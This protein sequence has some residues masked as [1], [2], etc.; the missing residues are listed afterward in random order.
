MMKSDHRW[1]WA[2]LL[3]AACTQET[4]EGREPAGVGERAPV[5]S[6]VAVPVGERDPVMTEPPGQEAVIDECGDGRITEAESCDDGN[7]TTGDGC[8]ARC[9][10]EWG[11][12]HADVVV[13]A[14]GDHFGAAGNVVDGVNGSVYPLSGEQ[15]RHVTLSWDGFRVLNGPGADLVVFENVWLVDPN[16][17]GACPV[18]VDPVTGEALPTHFMEE[19]V[20]EVSPDCERWVSYPHDYT[21]PDETRYVPY[22]DYWLG[23]A[24]VRVRMLDDRTNPVDPFVPE[25][26]GGDTF[27][28]SVLDDADPVAKAVLD[29]G[30]QCVRLSRAK[31]WINDD[32]DAPFVWNPCSFDG[33]G[34]PD[35]IYAR[36][37]VKE[38][39]TQ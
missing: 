39:M 38:E 14:P 1:I 20:L 19:M 10:T 7:R 5:V 22:Q 11:P 28:L 13:D 15:T 31:D 2:G 16:N 34:D 32:T 4:T 35:G 27:D 6:E 25:E 36:Y 26:A 24:G 8:S 21:A 30:A 12:A 29:R 17:V 3:C 9:E 33:G 23:F 18:A 37:L